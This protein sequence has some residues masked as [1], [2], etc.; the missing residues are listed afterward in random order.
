[1]QTELRRTSVGQ[2]REIAWAE[3]GAGEVLLLLHG[4]T[5]DHHA[6]DSSIAALSRAN[7]VIAVDL[8]GHGHSSP[9]PHYSVFALAEE[10][11]TFIAA[12][13]LG[14]PRL[15]GHSLGGIVATATAALCPVRSVMNVDQSLRLGTFIERV[16][17]IATDLASDRF[18]EVMNAEMASL[19]G[20]RLSD[21]VKTELNRYRV[22]ARQ[23]V[24]LD[25]WLPITQLTEDVLL[26]GFLP[27]LARIDVPYL[28]LHGESPGDRYADWLASVIRGARTEVWPG[29]GH[30]LH[31]VEP[32]RFID[33]V[34]TFHNNF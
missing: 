25:L 19:A 29:L 26:A 27:T 17:R 7:R 5:E 14:A 11:A 28:A 9:L 34:R 6:W 3:R 2:G 15:V 32:V 12:E 4:I 31:R 23:K 1:M 13:Q 8:P 16:R 22:P 21:D 33:R 30:W 20:P 10:I 18:S 24:V